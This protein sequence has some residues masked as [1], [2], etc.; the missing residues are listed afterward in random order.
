MLEHFK[1]TPVNIFKT[2]FSI[3]IKKRTWPKKFTNINVNVIFLYIVEV[4]N[5]L[6]LCGGHS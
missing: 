3:L 4:L 5:V 6:N 2:L 1:E